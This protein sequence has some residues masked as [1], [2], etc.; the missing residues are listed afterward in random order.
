MLTEHRDPDRFSENSISDNSDEDRDLKLNYGKKST[1]PARTE[2]QI[3]TMEGTDIPPEKETM[4]YLQ[5]PSLVK[6]D[7]HMGK[8]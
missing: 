4:L 3:F 5:R 7:M 2:S 6:S 1:R 8:D